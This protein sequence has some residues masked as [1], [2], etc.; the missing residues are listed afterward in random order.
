MKKEYDLKKMKIRSV[1]RHDPEAAKIPI[2]IRMDAI[3][4][5]KL[6]E[7]AFRIGIPYQTFIS[8]ILHKYVSGELI[9]KKSEKAKQEIREIVR[10][11]L[12]ELDK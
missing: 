3:I 11:T 12:E 2:S 8:S 6:R 4:L 9:E 10:A 1:G 5:I 7:E